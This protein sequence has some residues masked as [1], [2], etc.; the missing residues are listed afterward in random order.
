MKSNSASN[1]LPGLRGTDHLGITVP[2]VDQAADF[3]VNVIGCE[4]FYRDGPFSAEDD[5]MAT[6]LNVH[7][8]A[9]IRK[10]RWLRCRNGINFE[11]F[12][13]EAPDQADSPPKNSDIGGHHIAFYVDD[14]DA[15]LR[16]LLDHDVRVLGKPT[17]RTAGPNAGQTWVYFLAPWGMQL[18]LVSYPAGK[19]YQKDFENRLWH[20]AHPDA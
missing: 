8:D 11:L 9:V 6:N 2:D 5:W 19:G 16:H 12:E 4:L 13:Y 3:F 10:I 17:V 14:F 7:R 1:G 20:P 15:A 18:E